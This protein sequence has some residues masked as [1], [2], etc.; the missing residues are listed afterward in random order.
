MKSILDEL[1][2]H[3][4]Q[5]IVGLISLLFG[6]LIYDLE[7]YIPSYILNT[8]S[9]ILLAKV[10]ASLFLISIG[11]LVYSLFLR[12]KLSDKVKI[13]DY[14]FIPR[15]GYYTHKTNGGKFCPACIFPPNSIPSP[16]SEIGF[17]DLM[18]RKCDQTIKFVS[19]NI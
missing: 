13:S 18:C 15:P 19:P 1:K 16:L 10:V 14:N 7:N 5:I 9:T 6:K 3:I 2:L 8:L 4:G 12:H 17:G 11:L